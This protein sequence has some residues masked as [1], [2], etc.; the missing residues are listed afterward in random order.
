MASLPKC[1]R[2]INLPIQHGHDAMLKRMRRGYTVQRYRELA[3]SLRRVMPDIALSTDM[4]VGH[5]GETDEEFQATVDL[6]KELHFDKI[7]IAA[8]SSRPGTRAATLEEDPA[9]AV[10]EGVK[11]QRRIELERVQEGIATERSARL[12]NHVVEVL[13]EA[14]SK[15]KWRGRSSGNQLVFFASPDEWRGRVA[16]VRVTHTSPWSLSG[17]VIGEVSPD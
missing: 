16:R 6:V 1:P 2:E 9:Q 14:E 5:P 8:F 13:V 17:E 12:L 11:A 4:I 10:P 7:H 15:G 3:A